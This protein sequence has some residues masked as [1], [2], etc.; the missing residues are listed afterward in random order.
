MAV[1]FVILQLLPALSQGQQAVEQVAGDVLGR[2][3][4]HVYIVV[5]LSL[6]VFYSLERL[7]KLSRSQNRAA[8]RRTRPAQRSFGCIW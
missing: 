6:I 4:R 8:H 5:L 1:A 2:L 7:A 3:E